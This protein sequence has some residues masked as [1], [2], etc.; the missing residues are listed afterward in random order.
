MKYGVYLPNF[1]DFF[2]PRI[3]AE[4]AHEAEAAGWDGFFIWDHLIHPNHLDQPF[5]DPWIALAAVALATSHMQI[6]ALV[7]PIARRRPW[8]LAKEVVTLDHL[9]NGRLVFGAGLGTHAVEFERLGDEGS[10]Q[11][12]AELLDEGLEV[13]MG[14]CSGQDFEYYG[15]HY[16]VKPTRFLPGALQ[17]PRVPVWIAGRWPT[18]APLLRAARW[19]GYF[20]IGGLRDNRFLTPAQMAELRAQLEAARTPGLPAVDLVASGWTDELDPSAR[21][22]FFEAYVAAGATWYLEAFDPWHYSAAAAHARI[23][24]GP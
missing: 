23:R 6:G 15:R 10:P 9:S 14:L 19:D 18:R 24:Q 22:P 20:P 7:T 5:A 1:G 16:E 21:K 8:K 13:L 17:Q 2:D 4:T 12:R 11:V 3:L